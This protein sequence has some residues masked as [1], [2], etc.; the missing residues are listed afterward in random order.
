MYVSFEYVCICAEQ[1]MAVGTAPLMAGRASRDIMLQVE[2]IHS[3]DS[4]RQKT[5]E[6]FS[7][8]FAVGQVHVLRD[9]EAINCCAFCYKYKEKTC[10]ADML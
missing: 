7:K 3:P 1:A 6:L 8:L 2:R 10:A 4:P 5:I 9:T